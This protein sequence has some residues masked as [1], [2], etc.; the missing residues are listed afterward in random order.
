MTLDASRCAGES[1]DTSD[2][3]V[4]QMRGGRPWEL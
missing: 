1:G 2:D 4:K 3:T